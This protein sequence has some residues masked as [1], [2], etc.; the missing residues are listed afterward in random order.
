VQAKQKQS[1]NALGLAIGMSWFYSCVQLGIATWYAAPLA[2]LFF[3]DCWKTMAVVMMSDIMRASGSEPSGQSAL[4]KL[5]VAAKVARVT[6][7][8]PPLIVGAGYTAAA[9]W[10]LAFSSAHWIFPLKIFATVLVSACPCVVTLVEPLGLFLQNSICSAGSTQEQS[11]RWS[12]YVARSMGIVYLYYACSLAM[13][14]GGSYL[15]FGWW[16]NPWSAGLLMLAGQSALVLH[17]GA[18]WVSYQYHDKI[19]Q[20]FT[21]GQ[22]R[23]SPQSAIGL[24]SGCVEYAGGFLQRHVA[25]DF[26]KRCAFR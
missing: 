23:L 12:G 21:V 19:K 25:S 6:Q 9:L 13:A 14:C 1:F 11:K 22:M 26:L 8:L 10:A 16:M 15:C 2:A 24:L 4:H 17:T 7:V 5:Q 3:C 20:R 18:T